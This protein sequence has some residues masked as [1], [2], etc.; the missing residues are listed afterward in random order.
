MCLAYNSCLRDVRDLKTLR[1]V[2]EQSGTYEISCPIEEVWA[3]LNDVSVLAA[4]IPGCQS[5]EQID[6]HNFTASVKAKVGPVNA[7]FQVNIS[8]ADIQ[9]PNSYTLKG[10]VKG[11]AGVAKGEAKVALMGID[12]KAATDLTYA[13]TASV[14]GKLAQVGSRLVDSAARKMS[15]EFFSAFEQ[16]LQTDQSPH[17]AG[18][19]KDADGNIERANDGMLFIWATAFVVLILAMVLAI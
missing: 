18:P 16:Q 8:L 1:K 10:E 14:G 3:G 13:V 5:I 12:G 19:K 6:E 15:D 7:T 17:G 4:C 11:S 9:A 2:V